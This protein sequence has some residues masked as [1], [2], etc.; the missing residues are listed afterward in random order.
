MN[1]SEPTTLITDYVLALFSSIFGILLLRA[2]THRATLLW[3]I[4]FL[5]LAAAGLTGGPFHGLRYPV[6]ESAHRGLC[7]ITCILI[8]ACAGFMISAALTGS[9]SRYDENTRWLAA[10]LLVSV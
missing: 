1:I 6:S 3:A 8:G 10:G 2:R 4:G 9:L 7:N 5:T